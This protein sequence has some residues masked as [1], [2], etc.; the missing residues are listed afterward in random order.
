[1]LWAA[2]GTVAFTT[3]LV[4]LAGAIFQRQ[5][6]A[7]TG[8]A[9]E[10]LAA[11]TVDKLDRDLQARLQLLQFAARTN[12][13]QSGNANVA[14][15]RPWIESLLD[16]SPDFAWTG[17]ADSNGALVCGSHSLMENTRVENRP[18]F[19][20]GREQPHV[21]RVHDLPELA[22]EIRLPEDEGPTRFVDLS[23]PVRD[24]DG[25]LQGVL[26]ALM[27]WSW[28][29]D[30]QR[31]VVPDAARREHLGV[32]IYGLT[33]E[34]LLDSGGT[35]WN[36]PPAAPS[37]P[38]RRGLRG[39]LREDTGLGPTYLTGYARSQGFRDFYGLG[40][41]VAVRQ[42]LADVLAP[43]E[44]LRRTIGRWGFVLCVVSAIAA[45]VFAGRLAHR[46]SV[47]GRAARRIR[48]GDILTVLPRPHGDGE[49]AQMCGELGD[50]VED[51]RAKQE[52]AK[53]DQPRAPTG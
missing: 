47:I 40:W 16:A 30:V 19:L 3:L 22:R 17:F 24:N 48:E 42:P 53:R 52:N 10:T 23:V 28:A 26:V 45:W 25:Q 29:R 14:Q 4:W 39:S 1:M 46:L 20:A 33:G 21:G 8:Q 18:W 5:L 12:P 38:E 41:L 51:F 27:R 9:F 37:L 6:Q 50:M 2:A 13:L 32:T 49:L 15:L 7:R 34:V 31:S 11:Q 35:G 36:Q 43:V 44:E